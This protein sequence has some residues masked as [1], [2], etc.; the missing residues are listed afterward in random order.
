MRQSVLERIVEERVGQSEEM[1][2]QLLRK[3]HGRRAGRRSPSS[4]RRARGA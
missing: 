4:K 2:E 3:G 1:L